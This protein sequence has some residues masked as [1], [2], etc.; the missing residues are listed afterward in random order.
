M[1]EQ[2]SF[3]FIAAFFLLSVTSAS[4]SGT[5]KA[6]DCGEPPYDK[7]FIP[8]GLSAT[9]E[10]IGT[11]RDAV[12]SYSEKIDIYIVC[13]EERTALLSPYMT[14]DQRSR[15]IDTLNELA[16]ERTD[17]QLAVNKQIRA[18]RGKKTDEK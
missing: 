14:K 8:N 2:L 10:E 13:M 7:P 11:A 6:D 16:S 18:W 5:A 12:I 9:R 15:W 3:K 4:F 1:K 17:I